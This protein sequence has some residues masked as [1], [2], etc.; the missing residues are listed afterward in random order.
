MNLLLALSIAVGAA[1][2]WAASV[3]APAEAVVRGEAAAHEYGCFACHGPG[4]SAGIMNPGSAAGKVPGFDAGSM[5]MHVKSAAEFTEW[6]LEGEP[7][8]LAADEDE[9]GDE[10][11]VGMPAYKGVIRGLELADLIAYLKAVSGWTDPQRPLPDLAY[12][13]KV[14]AE[15][16]GCFACHGPSGV[17]G[18]PNPGSYKGYIPGFV[19][20]DY[21]ELVRSSAELREWILEGRVARLWKNPLARLYLKRQKTQMPAYRGK[22][23]EDEIEKLAAYIRWLRGS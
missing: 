14:L 3:E 19:G 15:R 4:G 7:K 23:S 22:L 10:G 17:G 20:E 1:P 9:D 12:E 18:V 16:F 21:A 8:R 2:L 13:G 11:L 6:I 5:A